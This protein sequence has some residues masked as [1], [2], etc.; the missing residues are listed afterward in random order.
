MSVF[1]F[2][3]FHQPKKSFLFSQERAIDTIIVPMTLVTINAVTWTCL[4]KFPLKEREEI[5]SEPWDSFYSLLVS[6]ALAFLLVFR[7][8][9]V[10][11]RWW[12]TRRMW[13]SIVAQT[14]IL[15]SAIMTHVSTSS[16]ILRYLLTS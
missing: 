8:N 4:I 6:T 9:R 15:G 10:A 11:V 1:H 16:D 7:L 12:D 5:D 13:G 3:T 2:F 14:R